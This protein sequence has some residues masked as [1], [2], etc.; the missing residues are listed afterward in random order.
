MGCPKFDV[1]V[2]DAKAAVAKAK[3]AI[4]GDGGTFSG[5]ETKGTFKD[6]HSG[7]LGYTVQGSYTV[8]DDTVSITTTVTGVATCGAVKDK[9]TEYLTK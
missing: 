8:Q 7:I 3:K 5:D 6:S 2:K 1:K 9:I 4:T